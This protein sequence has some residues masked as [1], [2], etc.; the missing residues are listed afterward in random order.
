MWQLVKIEGEQLKTKPSEETLP[1][2]IINVTDTMIN[3]AS[4]VMKIGSRIPFG[5]IS[6][7]EIAQLVQ[8][9][10]PTGAIN[11][12]SNGITVNQIAIF[13]GG[14]SQSFQ[15]KKLNK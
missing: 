2:K 13:S 6:K 4:L 1:S 12:P 9:T 3:L 5:L 15:I 10:I 14:I 11:A 7:K 8:T